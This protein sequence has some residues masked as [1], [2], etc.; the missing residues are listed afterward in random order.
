MLLPS[1][2]KNVKFTGMYKVE[3]EGNK[4]IFKAKVI[5]FGVYEDYMEIGF[6]DLDNKEGRILLEGYKEFKWYK[7]LKSMY[8]SIWK[9]DD[10]TCIES[11]D[12]IK[13]RV[14]QA[15]ESKIDTL[16]T[17]QVDD[18]KYQVVRKEVK[19]DKLFNTIVDQ[20][21]LSNIIKYPCTS[22]ELIEYKEI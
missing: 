13:H 7:N 17:S 1:K 12:Y 10:N 5:Q 19:T 8:N 11:L 16:D 3:I 9:N 21:Q 22:Y 20:I 18:L 6:Y 4:I 14:K 15:Q 2:L